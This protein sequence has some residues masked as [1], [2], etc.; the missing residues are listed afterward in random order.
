MN[1]LIVL[2]LLFALTGL[3]LTVYGWNKPSVL[4]MFF[5]ISLL[6]IPIFY[7]VK[8]L[9]SFIRMIFIFIRR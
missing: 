5:G 7:A 8:W 4:A 3:V 1:W 2:F 9:I 6:M